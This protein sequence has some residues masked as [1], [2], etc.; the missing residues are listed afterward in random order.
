MNELDMSRP[1]SELF[2]EGQEYQDNSYTGVSSDQAADDPLNMG[3]KQ[4]TDDASQ[5]DMSAKDMNFQSLRA[6]V[7]KA[8]EE[9]NYWRGK[10]EGALETAKPAMQQ[11]EEVDP[12]KGWDMDY[13]PTGKDVKNAFE[14]MRQENDKLREEMRDSM[15]ATMTKARRTD[16]DQKV[17]E[18]VPQL[19]STNPLFA[20]M[21]NKVS[22]PYEAA[23]L[24]AELNSKATNVQRQAPQAQETS[25]DAMRAL[26]NARKPQSVASI[27]GQSKLSAADYYANMSDKEFHELAARNLA[28]I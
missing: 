19:T 26:N 27:G 12:F 21:I 17:T 28:D 3:V 11:R 22:N 4:V 20:E 18:H 8:K 2:P 6:E 5:R 14:M 7:Q 10:S 9:A 24:L 23:Y 16:W 13:S 25:P 1:G 15:A